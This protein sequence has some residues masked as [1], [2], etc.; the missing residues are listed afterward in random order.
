[1]LQIGGVPLWELP[2]C[3]AWARLPM[4]VPLTAYPDLDSAIAGEASPWQLSL[5]GTWRFKLFDSPFDAPADFSAPAFDDTTWSNVEVPGNWTRQGFDVPHYTNVVMPF[6]QAPPQ[7]PAQNPT[8][9]YRRHFRP[10]RSWRQ[11][12]VILNVGGAESVL[13]VYLNGV[14]IGLSKDSR[15]PAEFDLTAHVRGGN[16][17]LAAMVIRWSDAS[18]LEDQDHWWMAGIHRDVG[19][20]S[21]GSVS[22]ANL[23]V[24]AGLSDDLARGTLALDAEVAAGEPLGDGWQIRFHVLTLAGKR[25]VRREL[26]GPVSWFRTAGSH[27][28]QQVSAVLF[29]GMRVTAE[30]EVARVRPWSHEDPHLYQVVCELV[31]PAGRVVE[32]VR[33]RFGFRRVEVRD[34]QLL[35]NGCAVLIRGVNRHDHDPVSGKVVSVEAMREDLVLMKRFN[36]NAVRTAHYPNDHHFYDLCDELGLYVVDEANIES[37]ARQRSLV[38]DPRYRTAFME[39]FTRMVIRDGN[40]PSIIAWSLGNESGYGEVFEAMAAWARAYDPSR[41]LHYEGGIMVPWWQLEGRGL[42]DVLADGGGLDN[43]ATDLICPMYPSLEALVRFCDEYD[44]D[45]PLIMCEYSHAMGNSNGGLKDYWELIESC[46]G[47]QGG[48]VWDWMD[49]G[50]EEYSTSG[51]AYYAFGGDYNDEPNDANFLVN[52]LVWPDRTPHPG[53]WEH[54]RLAQPLR[55]T[56]LGKRP[57]RVRIASRLDFVDSSHIKVRMVTLVDGEVVAEA[58]LAVPV[59]APGEHCDVEVPAPLVR[60]RAG[61]EL[62][63]RL[64]YEL[65]RKKAYAA[66]DHQLG[67]DEWQLRRAPRR[68]SRRGARSGVVVTGRQVRGDDLVV[69]FDGDGEIERLEFDGRNLLVEAPRLNLWRAPTD[70][71]GVRLAGRVGGVLARW[72]EWGLPHVQRRT[73]A[74]TVSTTRNR[75]RCERI[76]EHHLGGLIKPVCQRERLDVSAEGWVRFS[77]RI[78]VPSPIDDLPR[79]GLHLGVAGELEALTYFGR[80]PEENYSDRCHGLSAGPLHL[81]GK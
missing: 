40:H 27:N 3:V 13:L 11:R 39:R 45:K 29:E 60:L 48:F 63:V 14:F 81:H 59:L 75:Y 66:V 6:P 77:E 51:E 64:V 17:V 79:L 35:I 12:R 20:R 78:D 42:A 68:R 52:G 57:L 5:N 80:G 7:V 54:H 47:L 34:R 49:Q 10:P 28:A 33:Q 71:D 50:L 72:L 41:V 23:R 70:N 9:V 65:R 76:V 46:H 25:L 22:I 55:A 56:L 2:E 24:T 4:R 36:F 15:L 58:P 38:H 8:G 19:L 44:G 69:Q 53:L 43:L 1:M 62:G 74:M 26:G 61:G 30:V 18:F 32:A 67:W 37:H 73:V 16:N 31:D 21:A